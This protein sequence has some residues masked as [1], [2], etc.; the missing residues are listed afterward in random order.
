MLTET[1]TK[2]AS[3][4]IAAVKWILR[5]LSCVSASIAFMITTL[6][7]LKFTLSPGLFDL[8]GADRKYR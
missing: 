3:Y 7:Q 1:A 8:P 5:Y 2:A 4:S 6:A